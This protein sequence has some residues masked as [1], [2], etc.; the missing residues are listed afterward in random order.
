MG[1]YG[2]EFAGA[3]P[4]DIIEATQLI[5]PPTISNIVAMEAP[6]SGYGAYS[7]ETV[8]YIFSTAF[9]GFSA[10]RFDFCSGGASEIAIHTGFWRCGAYGG[11]RIL[12]AVLQIIAA[13]MVG[14]NQLVFHVLN[15]EGAESARQAVEFIRNGIHYDQPQMEVADIL[16]QIVYSGYEWGESDGN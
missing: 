16:G 4:E 15:D 9:T 5:V 3:D 2:N 11:N 6:S 7:A 14:I 12:M 8:E 1:L 13:N 10:A